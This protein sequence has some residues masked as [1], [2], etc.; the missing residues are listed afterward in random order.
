LTLTRGGLRLLAPRF[1]AR[2]IIAMPSTA[3]LV[4][5]P[6]LAAVEVAGPN[7]A[8]FLNG[9]LSNDTLSLA[10][11]AWQL[12]S[13][14][15]PKG[16]VVAVLSLGRMEDRYYAVL[17]RELAAP[18]IERLSK[19]ILRSKVSLRLVSTELAVWGSVA[20]P[21]RFAIQPATAPAPALDAIDTERRWKLARI[22]AGLPQIY[23]ATAEQFVA[24]MINLDLVQGVSFHKGCY[25]GQEIIARTQNLG[26]IKRR[27]L[28]FASG[29]LASGP[30]PS[31]PFPNEDTGGVKVGDVVTLGD[32]GAA[33]IVE[34]AAADA[35]QELLAVV[36]LEP[37]MD[38]AKAETAPRIEAHERPLPYSIPE[39]TP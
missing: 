25:T 28:R 33:H 34:L 27:M 37:R 29:P 14:S 31:G 38:T 36:H 24:Q 4:S 1:P 12:T 17:P 26:R 7:A 9:Q 2:D 11:G 13:W 5:L 23:P 22:A 21:D 20:S 15:T 10:P 18:F 35:G 16:R 19:Y 8:Q 3:P 32:F 6:H 30:F 39:R